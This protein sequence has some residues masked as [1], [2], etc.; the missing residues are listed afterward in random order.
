[1][2]CS[3]AVVMPVVKEEWMQIFSPAASATAAAFI[4]G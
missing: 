2:W 1:M 3:A 4:I